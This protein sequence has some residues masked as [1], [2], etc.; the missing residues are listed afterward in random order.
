[1]KGVGL[2]TSFAAIPEI[3][4]VTLRQLL[5]R[6]RAILLLLL[7]GVPVLLAILFRLAGSTDLVAFT[8]GILHAVSLTML[9][10]LVAILFGTAAFGSEIEDGTV[11]Y[12]LAKPVGRWAIVLAKLLATV[13][14]TMGLTVGSVLI[15]S[16]IALPSFGESGA[17]AA[18]AFVAAMVVGSFCY[19]SLF[20]ALTLFTRRAL[21]VGIGYWLIW[22]GLLST[23][24]TGIANLSVRQYSLGVA[25]A[26]Y[27]FRDG[28]VRVAPST[29]LE[30]ATILVVVATGVAVWKL[31]RFELPGGD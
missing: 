15:A 12:L 30:L 18:R 20:L 17:E 4:Y 9:L 25:S 8:G 22:E 5:G 24:M 19:V 2:S 13:G 6:R 11:V 27:E 29:A 23:L 31:M 14:V 10:P 7:S 3:T 1:M 26:F 21:V 28:I 16:L